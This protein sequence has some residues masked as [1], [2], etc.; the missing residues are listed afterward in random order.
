MKILGI[1]MPFEEFDA[2]MVAQSKGKKL[3]VENGKVVAKDYIATQEQLIKQK[4]EIL[5]NWFDNFFDKQLNQSLWQ[6]NFKVSS[7]PY[8]K[9]DNNAPKTYATIDALKEQAKIVR[10]TIVELR[11]RIK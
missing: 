1:E 9:D 7:D 6:D 8:F 10:D 5:E 11:K 3:V 2:L 4:I